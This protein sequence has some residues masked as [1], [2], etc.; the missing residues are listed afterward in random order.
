M[1]DV[2]ASL[3]EA[4]AADCRLLAGVSGGGDSMAL[5]TILELL[6]APLRLQ[7]EVACVDH[8]LRA[9]A[10]REQQLAAGASARAGFPFHLLRVHPDDAGEDACR[11]ARHAALAALAQQRAARWIVLAHTADD[12]IETIMLKFLRGAGPGGLAG[13]QTVAGN[14]LRPLL[15]QRRQD[16]RE[17]LREQGR[18]WADDASN[19]AERY[20]R[21]RLR[22]A[23][24][25]AIERA[26]GEGALSHLLDTARHWR[27]DHRYLESEA[28]RLEAYCRRSG[29]GVRPELDLPSLLEAD[30]ALR[31][32]VLQRWLGRVSSV[33]TPD[34]SYV[35]QLMSLVDGSRGATG[36]DLPGVRVWC[37]NGRLR[38]ARTDIDATAGS[39]D[40]GQSSVLPPGK[41]RVRLRRVTQ[42]S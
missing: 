8:G 31:A 2:R 32:R 33:N 29:G 42:N 14:L 35:E 20:A 6:A 16:L 40:S 9:E 24:L 23:V 18:S 26:F 30:E 7:V 38:S 27:R 39:D 37:E 22:T 21:G 4:G 19:V 11:R 17:L 3:E 25:P 1:A 28:T 36:L 15:E 41:G 34:A 5:L 12:Q 10:A 13:M